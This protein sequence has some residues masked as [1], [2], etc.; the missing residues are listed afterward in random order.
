M[1]RALVLDRE[2]LVHKLRELFPRLVRTRYHLPDLDAHHARVVEAHRAGNVRMVND[3]QAQIG[4]RVTTRERCDEFTQILR[5][6]GFQ[7]VYYDARNQLCTKD[8][9]AVVRGIVLL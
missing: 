7:P 8:A 1:S 5:A 2:A 3:L 9:A 6:Y 4:A